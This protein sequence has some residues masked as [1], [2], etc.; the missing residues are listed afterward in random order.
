[1]ASGAAS[2]YPGAKFAG[3]RI[4]ESVGRG[5]MAEVWR[6]RHERLGRQVA[7]KILAEY[8]DGEANYRIRFVRESKAAAAVD[9]PNIIPVYDAGESDGILF[10]AMRYVPGGDVRSL[11]KERGPLSP[12]LTASIIGPVAEA[13]D[14]AHEAGI[15]HRDVKPANML[16]DVRGN[17]KTHVYLADFGITA[18]TSNTG[19]SATGPGTLIGTLDYMSPEQIQGQSADGRAD[20]WALACSAFEMLAGSP[21]YRR[22]TM[23]ATL[24]AIL[25]EELPALTSIRPDLPGAVDPVFARAL[26]KSRGDRYPTCSEFAEALSAELGLNIGGSSWAP[27]KTRSRV[28]LSERYT[29]Y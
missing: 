16:L 10:I 20:Q 15:V 3:Y 29:I 4:E 19:S 27:S 1:M 26:A 24:H 22:S 18:Y 2:I 8:L 25:Q 11:M 5:G 21:P 6:A 17:G 7:L 12:E 14:A 9:H 13:L 28:R 23:P